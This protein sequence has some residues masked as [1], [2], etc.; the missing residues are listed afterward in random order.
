MRTVQNWIGGS[1]Y[2]PCSAVFVPPPPELVH[3]LLA[4]LCDF[5]NDD[6]LP[7][8]AQAA[9]AHAQFETIHPFVDGNGRA[10]RALIHLVLRRRGTALRMA[11]PVSLVLATW[12]DHYVDAL[13]GTRYLGDF[14]S[15]AAHEGRNRWI[16]L[17]AAACRRS[18]EDAVR[19]EARLD[20]LRRAWRGQLVRVRADSAVDLLLHAVAGAP[21]VTVTSASRLIARSF[22]ATNE[23][24][25]RLAEAGILRPV[26]VARRNRAF[27]AHEVIDAFSDFERRLANPVSDTR[28][29]PPSRSFPRRRQHW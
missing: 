3:E 10:G 28:V 19:F 2:N 25:A 9:I 27:E 16:A 24:V 23:A 18:V 20:E 17:F 5:C 8:V 12:S 22:Q 7:A 13:T 14:G 29:S 1:S 21:I 4:D 15:Q 26:T 6:W 11:P